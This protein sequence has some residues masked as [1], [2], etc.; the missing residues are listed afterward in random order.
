[1]KLNP[2]KYASYFLFIA[3]W[4][5]ILASLYIII[6]A[7]LLMTNGIQTQWI[8]KDIELLGWRKWIDYTQKTS[9]IQRLNFNLIYSYEVWW[10]KYSSKF[11]VH[12]R[13]LLGTKQI[14][15]SL[16]IIYSEKYPS[17]NSNNPKGEIYENIFLIII[18]L[19]VIF[20]WK[21]LYKISNNKKN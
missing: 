7:S 10:E 20:I 17:I 1:M 14:W 15:D 4:L 3:W 18:W 6:Q 2:F 13:S 5:R 21:K 19:V 8:I 16:D 12:R 9:E 11:F